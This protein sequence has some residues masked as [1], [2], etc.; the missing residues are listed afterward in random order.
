MRNLKPIITP[1]ENDALKIILT[2][3][4]DRGDILR[5]LEGD[6]KLSYTEYISLY[7]VKQLEKLSLRTNS[8]DEKEALV[9]CYNSA[10][11]KLKKARKLIFE[12]QEPETQ[13]T[14]QY[15]C[16]G[17]PETLDHYAPKGK[18]PYYSIFFL[19]LIPCCFRCN[20]EKDETWLDAGKNREF[21]NFYNDDI[22]K[23][24]FLKCK[25]IFSTKNS[26][27]IIKYQL[28][29]FSIIP[30]LKTV[31]ENHF[32]NLGL[33]ELYNSKNSTTLSSFINE[34]MSIKQVT[35]ESDVTFYIARQKDNYTKMY[36]INHWKTVIYADALNSTDFLEYI[37]FKRGIKPK[38]I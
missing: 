2:R 10:P 5:T 21:I 19:N 34:L 6:A 29:S 36:G 12:S 26:T 25:F 38:K 33:I 13:S 7:K 4:G 30:T 11:T 9:Y 17:S 35:D 20:L 27:P 24:R 3:Q 1:Y 28:D 16:F 31:V 15:C 22:P 37:L 8:K 14:C 32:K 23:T 18:F